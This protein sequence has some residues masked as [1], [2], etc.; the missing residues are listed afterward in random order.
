L[1]GEEAL[2]EAR[3]KRENRVLGGTGM[4]ESTENKKVGGKRSGEDARVNEEMQPK[5]GVGMTRAK[6]SRTSQ[7]G[8]RLAHDG[9]D[10]TSQKRKG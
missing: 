6:K 8:S 7:G 9:N 10:T 3:G 4:G 1:T 2:S 5:K